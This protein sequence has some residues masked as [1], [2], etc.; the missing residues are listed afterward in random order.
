M[1]GAKDTSENPTSGSQLPRKDLQY[2]LLFWAWK[3][4]VQKL[5]VLNT[6]LLSDLKL[7]SSKLFRTTSLPNIIFVPFCAIFL[8]NS[9][10]R[11]PASSALNQFVHASSPN[12]WDE[13]CSSMAFFKLS[14]DMIS[15]DVPSC[16]YVL[17]FFWFWIFGFCMFQPFVDDICLF[18]ST[19]SL[20]WDCSVVS[21]PEAQL[22][23][24]H[25]AQLCHEVPAIWCPF[26][27]YANCNPNRLEY[28][29]D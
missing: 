15:L 24:S 10:V 26:W 17:F 11:S 6:T 20:V 16:W 13:R 23:V 18:C 9:D 4:R 12:I 5:G 19:T 1:T 7:Q 22:F 8:R 29:I 28:I 2:K 3:S 21:C 14:L 27:N 25:R